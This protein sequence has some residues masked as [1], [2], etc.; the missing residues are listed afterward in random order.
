MASRLDRDVARAPLLRAQAVGFAWP[1][2]PAVLVDAQF[3]ITAGLSLVRGG[4]GRGKTTVLR[5]LA[6]ECAPTAGR[7]L[8]EVVPQF[9]RDPRDPADDALGVQTW[10]AREQARYPTWDTA[11]AAALLEG[12]AL[13]PHQ[14][15]ALCQLSTGSRR[16]VWLV[17]ALACGAPLVLLDAPFSALDTPARVLLARELGRV[18]DARRQAFVIA[19]V[20]CPPALAHRLAALIDLGD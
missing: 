8:R 2:G 13:V 3:L 14:G 7:L 4:D 1:E 10:L 19:D 5:L 20:E 6:G 9:W 11:Y 17:A 15:K 12:F 18:A 16:K